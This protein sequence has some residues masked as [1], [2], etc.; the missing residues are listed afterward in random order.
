MY[1][2]KKLIFILPMAVLA[3]VL[4]AAA[5]DKVQEKT[6][7]AVLQF[8][9]RNISQAEAVILSD[10]LRAELVATNHFNVLER[11]QMDKILREQKLQ[12]TG[13]C[14]DASCL[15]KVGQLMAVTKMMGGTISKIGNTYT[16]QAR[17]I[18]VE[19]GVIETEVSQ[20]FTGTIEDVQQWGMKKVVWKMVPSASLFVSSI[21]ADADVYWDAR[22][23]GKTDLK[24]ENE[25]L[26]SHRLVLKKPGYQDY[27]GTVSLK[28][29][30]DYDMK[31]RLSVQQYQ[32]ALDGT[33]A[34]AE[35]WL[36]DTVKVGQL[37][38]SASLPFGTYNFKFKAKG[39]H[40]VSGLVAIDRDQGYAL[41]LDLKRK[42][43]VKAG[44]TSLLLPG[45]GQR[46]SDRK[47]LGA[48]YL[49]A[50]LG[51][52][53]WT[54]V[55][56]G[57]YETSRSDTE[58]AQDLYNQAADAVSAQ[59]A[60]EDWQSQYDELQ[61]REKRLKTA[62]YATAGLWAFQ[63]IDAMAFFPGKPKVQVV[64][65][66]DKTGGLKTSLSLTYNW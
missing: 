21:P 23:V 40:T 39:Y 64:P 16:V 19:K 54:G 31:V 55:S 26:G 13:A 38:C 45:S 27:E 35:V 57:D 12:L 46:H 51:G 48:L 29:V 1:P 43:R 6:A 56:I 33:P 53:G 44:F 5:Q 9:P 32:V 61:T 25:A 37:P 14:S 36:G 49:V 3:A 7:V 41:K 11:E 18:D 15:V 8:E 52:M 42:S 22:K 30:K 65:I 17:V 4:P 2:I 20:D 28:E 24:I 66:P 63:F 59:L 10:R 47:V 62:I 34:G 60:Y 58:E 50:W